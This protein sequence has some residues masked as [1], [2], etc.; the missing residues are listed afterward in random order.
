MEPESASMERI[1][2]RLHAEVGQGGLRVAV[3]GRKGARLQLELAYRING[4]G[5]LGRVSAVDVHAAD[6]DPVDQDLVAVGLAAVDGTREAA[7]LGARHAVEDER[8][9]LPRPVIHY[10]RPCVNFLFVGTYA[11]FRRGTLQQRCFRHDRN[12]VG[13]LS[14]L[15]TEIHRDGLSH[16]HLDVVGNRRLEAAQCRREPV[17]AGRNVRG[18]VCAGL[19]RYG[20]SDNTCILLGNDDFSPGDNRSAGILDDSGNRA[21]SALRERWQPDRHNQDA[22]KQN[23]GEFGHFSLPWKDK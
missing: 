4:R 5:E 9:Q 12:L 16:H 23:S 15:E 22:Q 21:A 19:R 17:S 20:P 6:R 13:Y 8:L 1:R 3:L 10:D 2:P 18:A 14:D 7:A 11:D